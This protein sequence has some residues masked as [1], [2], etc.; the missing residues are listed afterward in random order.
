VRAWTWIR[1]FRPCQIPARRTSSPH[2]CRHPPSSGIRIVLLDIRGGVRTVSWSHR[3]LAIVVRVTRPPPRAQSLSSYVTH[4]TDNDA[5]CSETNMASPTWSSEVAPRPA[6]KRFHPSHLR[7][8]EACCRPWTWWCNDATA[9]GDDDCSHG[10]NDTPAARL[11]LRRTGCCV[12]ETPL[13]EKKFPDFYFV[14]Y[15]FAGNVFRRHPVCRSSWRL[16]LC[17]M[18]G[19]R[20]R[21][22]SLTRFANSVNFAFRRIRRE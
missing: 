17:R 16:A 13:R 22:L 10:R 4:Y 5:D 18:S 11:C 1:H 19:G 9:V 12:V 21:V 6:T 8:L 3:Q 15:Q 7:P 20:S 14:G 2:L